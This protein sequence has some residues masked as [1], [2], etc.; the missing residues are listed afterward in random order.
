MKRYACS[1]EYFPASAG[2]LSQQKQNLSQYLMSER[3]QLEKG[4]EVGRRRLF[5]SP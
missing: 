3:E 4:G 5:K 2:P 1:K